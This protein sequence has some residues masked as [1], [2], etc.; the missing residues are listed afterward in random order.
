MTEMAASW[1]SPQR[2]AAVVMRTTAERR[3]QLK[4]DARAHGMT[5]QTYCE[6][7]LLGLAEPPA[8]RAPGRPRNVDV[9]LEGLSMNE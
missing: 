9:P 2:A 1:R 4:A 3:E 5:L 6:W 8:E 7:K